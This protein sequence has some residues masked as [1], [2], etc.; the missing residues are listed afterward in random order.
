MLVCYY[1]N[2]PFCGL[3]IYVHVFP[4]QKENKKLKILNLNKIEEMIGIVLA[5][6][7]L[8][9]R[10]CPTNEKVDSILCLKAGLEHD[11]F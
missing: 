11:N 8:E 6:M 7:I 9:P 10:L 2:S 5:P 3:V 4:L 1:S